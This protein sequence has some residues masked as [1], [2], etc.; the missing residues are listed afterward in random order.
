MDDRT[1]GRCTVLSK[2][3]G[4]PQR[5]SVRVNDAFSQCS[6]GGSSGTLI[7]GAFSYIFCGGKGAPSPSSNES[8]GEMGSPRERGGSFSWRRRQLAG[9]QFT[10][11]VT[12]GE[13]FV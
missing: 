4:C 13:F 7:G 10:S 8:F 1:H 3:R 9:V 12:V 2:A 5:A 11:L 6:S